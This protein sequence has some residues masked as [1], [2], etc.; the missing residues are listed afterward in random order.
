MH[1][2]LKLILVYFV[3]EEVA[4]HIKTYFRIQDKGLSGWNHSN[5]KELED[6][7]HKTFL[8]KEYKDN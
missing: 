4:I 6:H 1:A 3:F 7:S 2:H 8:L 5:Y